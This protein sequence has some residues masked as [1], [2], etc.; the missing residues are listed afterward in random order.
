MTTTSFRGSDWGKCANHGVYANWGDIDTAE[1][2]SEP[3][4]NATYEMLGDLVVAEFDQLASD[5]GSSM[6]WEPGSSEVYHDVEEPAELL[7]RADG[8]REEAQETI[9]AQWADG[10]IDPVYV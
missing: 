9:L 6:S 3:D 1:D 4:Y 8:F 2:G 5:A 7:E 10:D